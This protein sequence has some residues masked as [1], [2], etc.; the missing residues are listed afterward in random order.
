MAHQFNGLF[1]SHMQEDK[2]HKERKNQVIQCLISKI[3]DPQELSQSLK[4]HIK[5]IKEE[6]EEIIK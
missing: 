4:V 5:A 2:M 1:E 6:Q 3:H